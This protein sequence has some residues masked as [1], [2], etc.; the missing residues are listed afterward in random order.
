M[1]NAFGPSTTTLADDAVSTTDLFRRIDEMT[2]NAY[3]RE[4]AKRALEV[5]ER[6]ADWLVYAGM[7]LKS[8]IVRIARPST[9]GSTL[10]NL[11]AHQ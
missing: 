2:M 6:I 1:P 7:K 9:R 11:P 3:D 8:P 4:R 10:R 5:A